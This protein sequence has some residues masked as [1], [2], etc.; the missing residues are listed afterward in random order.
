VHAVTY[1]TKADMLARFDPRTLVQLTDRPADDTVPPATTITDSVLD[2]AIADAS[3]LIDSYLAVIATLPLP[4][5]PAVLTAM[6]CNL[7]LAALYR[8]AMPDHVALLRKNAIGWLEGVRDN[9]IRLFTDGT[10]TTEGEGAGLP[11]LDYP[12]RQFDACKLRDVF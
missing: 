8:D 7:V 3:A 5:V 11:E 1:C 6:A 9:K 12:A 2:Q 4:S 10:T